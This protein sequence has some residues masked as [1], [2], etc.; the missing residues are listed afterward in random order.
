MSKKIFLTGATGFLGSHIARKLIESDHHLILSYREHSD[1]SRCE[2]F[3]NQAEW[4][5]LNSSGW[6]YEVE[7]FQPEIMMN[8][9][10]QGVE[11]GLRE[12][13]TAQIENI[14]FQQELLNLAEK[15]KVKTFIGFGSQAE[16]GDTDHPAEETDPAN[17]TTAYGAIKLAALQIAKLFCEKYNIRWIWLRLFSFFGEGESD[18]WL[19]PSIIKKIKD[20]ELLELTPGEQQVA[21]IYVRDLAEIIAIIIE[22]GISSGIYNISGSQLISIKELISKIR[23]LINPAYELHFGSIPYRTNQPMKIIG[24]TDKL[25]NKIKF[26]ILSN[27]DTCIKK[28]IESNIN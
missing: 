22:T 7:R 6:K 26:P 28:V 21:Y 23:D 8:S 12:N 2:D 10:W 15:I 25:R 17:A 1:F 14:F 16:Y 3:K 5:N 11:S 19:I 20:N 24:N 13:W 4:T 18:K 27:I 9:A